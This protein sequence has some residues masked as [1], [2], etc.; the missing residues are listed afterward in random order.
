[1]FIV[2]IITGALTVLVGLVSVRYIGIVL[3]LQAFF[4]TAFFPV[5]LVAMR[6]YSAG[7]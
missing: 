6:K 1:M 5:G 2:M 4:V 7:K 3:F